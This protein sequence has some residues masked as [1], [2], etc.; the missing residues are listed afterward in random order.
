MNYDNNLVSVIV[1]CYNGEKYLKKSIQSILSQ[2][3]EKFE[4]IFWDNNSTDNSKKVIEEFKDTRI[5]YYKSEK[6][7]KLY[8][9]RNLAIQ[10]ANGKFI[11]FLDTDDWWDENKLQIQVSLFS[12]N[13]DIG[14][15]YTNFFIYNEFKNK[16]KKFFNGLLP[17]GYITQ[18][19]L[20]YYR[21]GILTVMVKK[22]I[23]KK[24]KF[25]EKFE[26][27]GDFD[28]F[29][30]ISQKFK[31]LSIQEPLASYRVHDQNFSIERRNLHIDELEKWIKLNKNHFSEMGF[32]LKKQNLVL[33]KLKIR[34]FF[35]K[36]IKF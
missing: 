22:D 19:L 14:F 31:T 7:L 28:F 35:E 20:D 25:N 32:S 12:N 23:F 13:K 9:A 29:I 3:Y 1:N 27:I 26:I 36:I 21:I 6:Y 8:N 18:D 34:Y 33:L 11:T 24:E 2:T 15:I 16:K 5:K 10:K 30:K 4:I 17:S